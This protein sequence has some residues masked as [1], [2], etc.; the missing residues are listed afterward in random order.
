M[1]HDNFHAVSRKLCSE[2]AKQERISKFW[3][4]A[5]KDFGK[6][7]FKGMTDDVILRQI[8]YIWMFKY[9]SVHKGH[10]LKIETLA[11][12]GWLRKF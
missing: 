2:C 1:E 11:C 12:E 6:D 4:H 5:E 10:F 3:T 7:A 9:V 8:S